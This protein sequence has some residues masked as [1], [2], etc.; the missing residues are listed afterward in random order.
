MLPLIFFIN[1]GAVVDLTNPTHLNALRAVFLALSAL[2]WWV[3]KQVEA[4]VEAAQEK[5]PVWIKKAKPAGG[6]L[7]A[8]T[9]GGAAA[10]GADAGGEWEATTLYDHEKKLLQPKLGAALTQ[11]LIQMALSYYMGLHLP[12]VMQL[13]M[14]PLAMFEDPLV[15]RHVLQKPA[16]AG[17]PYYGAVEEDPTGGAATSTDAAA[18]IAAAAATT[19]AVEGGAPAAIARAPSAGDKAAA[20]AGPVDVACEEAVYTT[21]ENASEPVDLLLLQGLKA[22]GKPIG[23]YATPREGW[24]ALMCAAGGTQNGA[25]EVAGVLALG[26]NPLAQD[27]DGWTALHWAG[28]HGN[29]AAVE[30]ICSAV[31]GGTAGSSSAASG[32]AGRGR[33][34]SAASGELMTLL[35]VKDAKGRTAAALASE[36]GHTEVVGALAKYAAALHVGAVGAAAAASSSSS[37]S[38]EPAGRERTSTPASSASVASSGAG[39]EAPEA[40][41]SHG[42]P[43]VSRGSS[44]DDGEPAAAAA[45]RSASAEDGLRA[46]KR[47]GEAASE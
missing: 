16:E 2:S 29:A 45:S 31:Y 14:A 3:Y 40:E 38:S 39:V 30:A 12:W 41:A 5:R 11:P 46:R 22:S 43:S 20:A 28:Y 4:R 18:A 6:L 10:A 13:V 27:K 26:A 9:G 1:S 8:F 47:G 32:G 33:A 21:W 7:A 42:H 34:A 35:G 24:T 25:R 37:S 23:T 17:K 44:F 19:S 36:R 15:R